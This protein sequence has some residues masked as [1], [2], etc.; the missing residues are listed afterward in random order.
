ML[1][2]VDQCRTKQI[3]EYIKSHCSRSTQSSCDPNFIKSKKSKSKRGKFDNKSG[4]SK[5]GIEE[6]L[7]H[8]MRIL[9][10]S[11]EMPVIKITSHIKTVRPF[12]SACVVENLSFT[13]ET[14]KKFI[15]LQTKLHDGICEKRNI[16]T[17]ATHDFNSFAPGKI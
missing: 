17:I 13:D 3:L 12:I 2:L 7:T 16:A 6:P 15:Q 14:F 8:L 1:K 10:L 11:D 4:E 9:K 5:N